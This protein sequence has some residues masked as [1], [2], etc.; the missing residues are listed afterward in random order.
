[1]GCYSAGGEKDDMR[2]TPQGRLD[3]GLTCRKWWLEPIPKAIMTHSKLQTLLL[4]M[5]H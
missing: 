5:R 2:A 3:L 1:V 4:E